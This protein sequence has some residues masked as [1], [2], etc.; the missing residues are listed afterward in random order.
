VAKEKN[1][2]NNYP[3]MKYVQCPQ[4]FL[5]MSREDGFILE[6]R[7]IV[8]KSLNRC[9]SSD[10]VVHH[11]DHNPLNNELKNLKLFCTNKQHKDFEAQEKR[12]LLK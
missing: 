11:I 4:S 1:N 12:N 9:L 8:A 7:L 10:E 5:P 6:H 3:P 2:K